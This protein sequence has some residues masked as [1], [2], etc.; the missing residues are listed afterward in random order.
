M[1]V[2]ELWRFLI[3]RCRSVVFGFSVVSSVVSSGS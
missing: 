1:L 3:R 2:L